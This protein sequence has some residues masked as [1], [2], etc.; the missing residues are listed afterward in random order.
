MTKE[1]IQEIAILNSVGALDGHELQD[2]RTLMNDA[3]EHTRATFT[4][5]ESTAMNLTATLPLQH[6]ALSVREKLMRKIQ[7]LH[8]HERS[9]EGPASPR[10]N[11][12]DGIHSVFA[13]HMEWSK[14]PVPGV[15]FKLLSESKKR[16]YVTMLMKVEPG[17]RFPEHH[18]TGEEECYVIRGSITLNGKRLG[19]GVLHHGD[20][21][22]D[23]GVL[24]TDEGAML[25][26]V[27]AKEDYIQ[28]VS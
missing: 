14:H 4:G 17:T 10:F 15:S 25:L 12:T 18:H 22:S 19:A 3:D 1:K 24:S 28:P 27:V 23:H 16:G 11:H 21:D 8:A 9:I 5:W 6:P 13:D 26:L 7:E 2:Y 20:E